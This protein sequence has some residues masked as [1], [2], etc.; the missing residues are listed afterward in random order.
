MGESAAAAADGEGSD[1]TGSTTSKAAD[2]RSVVN[3]AADGDVV[4]DVTFE[5]S[6][7]TLKKHRKAEARKPRPSNGGAGPGPTPGSA[8]AAGGSPRV[9]VAYRLRLD[10]LKRSS[11]YFANLLSNP[12]FREAG[13]IADAHARL[14]SMKMD[15]REAGV[16]DLPWVTVADDDDATKAAGREGP[17]EDMLRVLHGKPVRSTRATMAYVTTMA[18]T[19][20]R[21]DCVQ[22]VARALSAELKFKWPLTATRPLVDDA[23]RPT[24]AEQVL[25]QKVLVSWLLAQP[26]RLQQC[27]RELIM[28]GSSVWSVYHEPDATSTAAWWNLPDGIEGTCY[29]FPCA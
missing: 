1:G 19:A 6:I 7:E 28:R 27:S 5:T 22:V 9:R 17:F 23:G 11:K 8:A 29:T 13:L 16:D 20:D 18:V 14:A 26:M 15:P 24:E 12:Q 4:L 21:F 2:G 25:R 3:V 10:V